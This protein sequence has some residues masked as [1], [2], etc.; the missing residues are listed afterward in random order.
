MRHKPAQKGNSAR[1]LVPPAGV[2]KNI[3]QAT[4]GDRRWFEEHP[5]A[6]F[7]ERPAV[8]GEF[9]PVFDSHSVLYVIVI[10]VAPGWRLRLPVV[11]LNR[12][13]S[14]RVQ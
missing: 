3:E 10:Q 2:S 14:G 6:T 9:W 7:R 4:G 5:G 11:R 13:G 1:T 12:P 8:A